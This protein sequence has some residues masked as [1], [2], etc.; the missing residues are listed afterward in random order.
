MKDSKKK[1]IKE[2]ILNK[3]VLCYL[4]VLLAFAFVMTSYANTI[5]E[6]YDIHVIPIEQY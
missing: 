1:I 3:T 6:W 4:I 5:V 2:L